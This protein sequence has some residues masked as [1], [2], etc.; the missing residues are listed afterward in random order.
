MLVMDEAAPATAS[1]APGVRLIVSR[2]MPLPD[3]GEFSKLDLALSQ[4]R[5]E[6]LLAAAECGFRLALGLTLLSAVGDRFGFWGPNGSPN[7]SWGDWEHFVHYCAAVN[8]FLPAALA[9]P[10]AWLAT[11]LETAFGAGLISGVFLR[12]SAYGSAALLGMFAAAMTI[13]FGIKSPLNFSVFV[14]AAG[15][16][17]LALLVEYRRRVIAAAPVSGRT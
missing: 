13:S 15:A 5:L 7:V 14:D 12:T 1:G 17:L 10:L 16:L 8:G 4:R 6:R 3:A 11:G 2:D 9:I